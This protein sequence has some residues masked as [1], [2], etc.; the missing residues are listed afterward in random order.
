[1][2][3]EFS[4]VGHSRDSQNLGSGALQGFLGAVSLGWALQGFSGDSLEVGA[5]RPG[6]DRTRRSG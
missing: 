3:W 2:V 6:R 5:G 1:M 4:G